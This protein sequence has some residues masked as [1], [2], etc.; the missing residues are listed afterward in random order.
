MAAKIGRHGDDQEGQRAIIDSGASISVVADL[1]K[2]TVRNI[3][4]QGVEI[5]GVNGRGYATRSAELRLGFGGMI[6]WV[7]VVEMPGLPITLISMNQLLDAIPQS[8]AHFEG[9]RLSIDTGKMQATFCRCD[10]GLVRD[11]K[12]VV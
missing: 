8:T 4:H 7:P 3:T 2:H 12:S 9:A 10:D 11:R 5:E 1:D 6:I